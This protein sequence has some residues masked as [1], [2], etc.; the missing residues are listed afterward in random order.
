MGNHT[1][2]TGDSVAKGSSAKRRES[3]QQADAVV[4]DIPGQDHQTV[5]GEP[6]SH[7]WHGIDV[8]CGA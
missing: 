6:D 2:C 1:E 3:E 8:E 5:V 7:E 4:N